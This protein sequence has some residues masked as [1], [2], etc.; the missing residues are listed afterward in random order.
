MQNTVGMSECFTGSPIV[1][2]S[3]GRGRA[4]PLTLGGWLPTTLA[5]T[6]WSWRWSS[7]HMAIIGLKRRL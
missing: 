5:T 6:V 2:G 3:A 7:L 4:V 1:R